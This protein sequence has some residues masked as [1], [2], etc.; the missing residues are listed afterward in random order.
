MTTQ[1][2]LD[3]LAE[4]Y[5]AAWNSGD[6]NAVAAFYAE[7]G[8]ITINRGTP[9]EGRAKVAEMAAGF[10]ADV[11]DLRLSCDAIR[12][13]G[14]HVIYVWTFTGH[15]ATSGRPLNVRGWEEWEL[16]ADLKVQKSLGWFD[17]EDYA[18]QAGG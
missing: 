15:D 16:D 1:D 12:G 10:F 2:T 6:P 9:W 5:T 18:R 11:P 3:A 13:A 8:G 7:G 14:A 17:A 4:A